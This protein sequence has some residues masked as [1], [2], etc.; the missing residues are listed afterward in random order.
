MAYVE[1][2]EERITRLR[3]I[4]ITHSCL[5]YVFD[6]PI[7]T[8]KEFDSFA[9]ELV[10]L[11]KKYPKISKSIAYEQEAYKDFDGSTGFDLPIWTAEARGK[12]EY[13]YKLHCELHPEKNLRKWQ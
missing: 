1:T 12:A 11:Q 8:D 4:L 7:W 2:T 9:Y 13:I 6:M 3:R 10:E 5:Y